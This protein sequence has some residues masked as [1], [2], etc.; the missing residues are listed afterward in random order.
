MTNISKDDA[1]RGVAGSHTATSAVTT[2]QGSPAEL[3]YKALFEQAHRTITAGKLY[4]NPDFSRD[5]YIKLCLANKNLVAQIVRRYTGTNLN[6]Y[7]NGLRL[8]HSLVLMRTQPDLPIK[9]VALD[10]GFSS[11]RSF[12]RLFM[13]R[14]GVTPTKFKKSL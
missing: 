2:R 11:L 9:A 5:T 6:G 4:L 13:A 3:R 8:E 14:Y 10:S 1:P 12:Y 7:I